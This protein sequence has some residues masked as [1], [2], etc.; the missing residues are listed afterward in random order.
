MTDLLQ[1]RSLVANPE[2]SWIPV[3]LLVLIVA[4]GGLLRLDHLTKENLWLDEY[5]ALYLATGRGNA[6][7]QTPQNQIL[8]HPPD[9]GFSGAPAWWHIWNG[10]ST[11]AH[12]P[13]YHIF[14]RFWVDCFG[15]RDGAIRMLST[16][17]SLGCIILLYIAIR[18]LGGGKSQALI[19]S[20]LMAL[21]PIEIY[22]SQQVRPYTMI[23]FLA[24]VAAVILISI[25]R[26]GSS[27][28][29]LLLLSLAILALALT[30]YFSAGPIAAFLIYSLLRFRRGARIAVVSAIAIA[31]LIALIAWG[32]HLHDYSVTGYGEIR[33]RNLFHL[34][35]SAPQRLTMETNQNPLQMADNGSWPLVLGIAAIVYLLPLITLRS[36]PELL[37]WWLW[38]VCGIGLVLGFDIARHSTLLSITRYITPA[39]PGVYAL[40]AA[41]LPT[42]IGKSVPWIVLAG[43]LIY[44]IDYCQM[45]PPDAPNVRIIS[46]MVKR[47]ASPGDVVIVTGDYYFAGAMGPPLTYFVVSHY[48]GPWSVPVVFGTAEITRSVQIQLQR[49][50]RIWVVGISPESDTRKILPGWRIHDIH[51]PGDSNLLWY[52]TPPMAPNS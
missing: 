29:K 48:A 23:Q 6:L 19:A 39:A 11:A 50:H 12:P 42:R 49:F 32:P 14:L 27:W 26:R 28:F 45:G 2:K 24:L 36:R 47:E 44:G 10:I 3:T 16:V 15:D 33:G 35:C 51:G 20:A 22:Y 17:F 38:S 21:A 7:F 41:P 46:D 52:V 9:A 37:L 34:I 4:F 30:H 8:Q 1:E 13:L 40:L 43:V 31:G 18:R 25:E 5:W